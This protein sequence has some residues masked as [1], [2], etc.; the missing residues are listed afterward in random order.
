VDNLFPVQLPGPNTPDQEA[1]DKE[2]QQEA[3]NE[4]LPSG[5]Q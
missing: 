2:Q 1:V 4:N 5:V 3:E